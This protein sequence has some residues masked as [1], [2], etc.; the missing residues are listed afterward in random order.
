MSMRLGQMLSDAYMWW[1]TYAY[2]SFPGRVLA[3][4]LLITVFLSFR[5]LLLRVL[6]ERVTDAALSYKWRRRMTYVF[7]V[8]LILLIGWIWSDTF[9]TIATLLGLVAAA[10]VLAL[11]DLV[12]NAAGWA[13]I[14][15]RRLFSVGDRIEVS[16]H[17]GDV[18]DI[19]LFEF[20]LL[21]VGN[22]VDADQ[23]TG[24]IIHVPNGKV[25]TEPLIN[26]TKDFDFIW[27]ELS[28]ILTFE[29]NWQRAKSILSG[30]A[31][32]VLA[33][34]SITARKELKKAAERYMIFFR[35]LTPI[36][37]TRVRENGV[38]LTIRYLTRPRE[39]R[40][41]EHRLWEEVLMRFAEHDDIALAYP[42]IRY[43]RHGEAGGGLARPEDVHKPDAPGQKQQ[44]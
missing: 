22:W 13:V 40:T 17:S 23:S 36:V 31:A 39:R 8:L 1:C 43:Y 27:N 4:I 5:V 26:Y 16:G 11:R 2:A 41:T 12:A 24:R 7:T 18:I 30:I 29:S 20:T 3:T 19:R 42:T 44:G 14:H 10:L 15:S 32:S 38:G 21:E 37:Y 9:H 33:D 6:H 25:L 28:V 34:A 35:N